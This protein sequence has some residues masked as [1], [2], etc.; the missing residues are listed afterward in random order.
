MAYTDAEK[1][2]RLRYEKKK[3]KRVPLDMQ[4]SYFDD[5]LKP[6]CKA[7]GEQTNTFI[8]KAISDRISAETDID[9]SPDSYTVNISYSP[10]DKLWY[11]RCKETE[12]LIES[13][14]FDE[15]LSSLYPMLSAYLGLEECK[16]DRF[17]IRFSP[18][19]IQFIEK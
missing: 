17:E 4:Q 18:S 14:S 15:L 5:V 2:A 9:S 10:N 6:A 13:R 16:K 3:L 19:F 11:A 12:I 8:K 7:V 1:N